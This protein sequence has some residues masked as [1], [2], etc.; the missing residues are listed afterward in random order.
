MADRVVFEDLVAAGGAAL[1]AVGVSTP[2][3][4]ADDAVSPSEIAATLTPTSMLMLVQRLLEYRITGSLT[5]TEVSTS[6]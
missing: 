5:L 4:L 3:E 1:I 6:S 2:C